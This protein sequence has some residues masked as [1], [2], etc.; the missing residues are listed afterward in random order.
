MKIFYDCEFLDD[1][2]T[3]E[4]I[5]IGMVADDPDQLDP[6]RMLYLVNEE[7]VTDEDLY[8]RIMGHEF[9]PKHVIPHLPLRP[10]DSR[11]DAGLLLLTWI[12]G[13]GALGNRTLDL[14]TNTVVSRRFMRNAVRDFI[15]ATPDPELWAYYGA[16]DHVMLAQLFGPMVNRPAKMPM[17]THDLMQLLGALGLDESALPPR[18]GD[19]HHALAD[20]Q[21][22]RAAWRH[23]T[24]LDA[25]HPRRWIVDE[26]GGRLVED[27]VTAASMAATDE[28]GC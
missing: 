24:A 26:S 11:N 27:R 13:P 12:G 16:Y 2:R 9:L 21:W 7:V 3:I 10:V 19:E 22:L 4:P 8:H 17:F 18:T 14:D 15:D 1:G 20:A 5:S 23:V 28:A 6:V 25:A